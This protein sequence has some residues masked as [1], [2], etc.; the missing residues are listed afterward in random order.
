MS[1]LTLATDAGMHVAEIVEI[2]HAA[3]YALVQLTTDGTPVR[4]RM[5]EL[6]IGKAA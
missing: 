3:G 1:N 4:I 6:S 2:N 5:S